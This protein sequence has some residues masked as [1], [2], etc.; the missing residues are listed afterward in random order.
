VVSFYIVAAIMVCSLLI[1]TGTGTEHGCLLGD[2]DGDRW[3]EKTEMYG[4]Q[5]RA[6]GGDIKTR[7][8]GASELKG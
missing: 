8:T 4:S 2:E 7:S 6:I 1:I 5:L 3:Q